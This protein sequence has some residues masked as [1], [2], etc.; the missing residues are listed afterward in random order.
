MDNVALSGVFHRD[1][2]MS[3][4]TRGRLMMLV[5]PGIP[6]TERRLHATLRHDLGD[7]Y[8]DVV[9]ACAVGLDELLSRRPL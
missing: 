2:V 1:L 9:D 4:C 3:M 6:I 7:T 5:T 8:E